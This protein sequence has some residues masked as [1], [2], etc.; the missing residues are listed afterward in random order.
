MAIIR[1]PQTWRQ[2]PP[3]IAPLDTALLGA[4]Y[5][6]FV[7][8]P[9][10]SVGSRS[11]T[12][13]STTEILKAPGFLRV[14][15]GLV[16]HMAAPAVAGTGAWT[17]LV[18]G[19][20][21][22]TGSSAIATL[23]ESP[24]S[25]TCDRSIG[26]NATGKLQGYA[27]D[28]GVKTALSAD[29]VPIGTAFS[30]A[31]TC[32]GA[33]L[34]SWLN[35]VPSTATAVTAAGFTGYT[36]P[37]FVIGYGGGP[38][39]FAT[40]AFEGAYV[41]KIERAL[42]PELLARIAA[43]PWIVFKKIPTRRYKAS[44]GGGGPATYTFGVSGQIVFSGAVSAR[45]TRLQPVSGNIA[46]SGAATLLRL[47]A[48]LPSGSI[49]FTGSV[50]QLRV[51]TQPPS[52]TIVFSGT[53][54]FVTSNQFTFA[55][56]GSLAFSGAAA[57]RRTRITVPTGSISFSR[58]V[59]LFHV[60]TVTV[61]GQIVFS[62]ARPLLRTEAYAPSGQITFSGNSGMTF[63]PFG[64]VAANNVNKISIGVNRT[65]RLS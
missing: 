15:S 34:I 32:D 57:Q 8:V 45:R 48:Q 4:D 58:N 3:G 38:L 5:Q 39:N 46:F 53:A 20:R 43:N 56:S 26:I 52:G 64:F 41:L 65:N 60:R 54:P 31:V 14:F 2:Q 47:R 19:I 49:S 11:N 44:G 7:S 21:N 63:I 1:R 17:I 25:S 50:N 61:S 59:T 28:G 24:G 30:G 40:C 51:R 18:Y 35:G 12:V 55:V 13:D 6:G 37:E 29:N 62:G 27:Y 36:D 22:A 33:N 23:A 10:R 16:A 42:E 9:N